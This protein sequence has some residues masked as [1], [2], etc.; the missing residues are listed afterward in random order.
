MGFK[1]VLSLPNFAIFTIVLRFALYCVHISIALFVDNNASEFSCAC[2]LLARGAVTVTSVCVCVSG[3][4]EA[5][6]LLCL[7]PCRPEEKIKIL[8]KKVN[9]LIEESCMA[10]SVGA[11]Q[12]V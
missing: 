9:D 11:L 2:T 6:E 3:I 7:W 12:L 4:L 1:S 8:E 10:Q 5:A